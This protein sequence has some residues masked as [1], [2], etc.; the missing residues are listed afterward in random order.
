[1]LPANTA[2]AAKLDEMADVLEQQHA[3]GYRVAAYRR[4]ARIVAGHESSIADMVRD[5]GLDGVMELPGV[6]RGIGSAVV[7][8]VTTGRWSALERLSGTLDPVQLFQT[9]PGIGTDLAGRIHDALHIDTLEALEVAA[10][11]GRLEEVPGIGGRRVAA[12]RAALAA[13][14]GARYI[15]TQRPSKLPPVAILLDVDREYRERSATGELRKIAPKRFN[16]EGE[17]W[18]P[19]LHTRRDE[20]DLTA[21][22]SNTQKAHELGR[23]HDWVVLYTHRDGEPESQCTVVTETRGPLT[24]RRVVR[25][26]EGECVAYYAALE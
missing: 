24:G 10:H 4:A 26:H 3:D 12:I 22:Y 1:M 13:R 7:E 17:A 20:W 14:L 16:P 9:I 15:R 21:L 19:V 25:G 6:G 23:T 5:Q 2:I 18:L 11:D 8:M